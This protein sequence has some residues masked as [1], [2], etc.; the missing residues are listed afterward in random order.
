MLP[1]GCAWWG[2]HVTRAGPCLQRRDGRRAGAQS[3][4]F[5]SAEPSLPDCRDQVL[6]E[7]WRSRGASA[8]HSCDHWEQ[9][10]SKPI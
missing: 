9:H 6:M 7:R 4:G 2:R 10:Q 1:T 3:P 8:P 5:F